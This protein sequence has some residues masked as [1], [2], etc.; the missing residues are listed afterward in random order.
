[1]VPDVLELHRE[2]HFSADVCA[3]LPH[4]ACVLLGNDD[5]GCGD[6]EEFMATSLPYM[7]STG[8]ISKILQKVIEARR[9]DRFTQDFLETK[10]GFSGGSA[11]AMIPFMKRLGFLANDGSPTEL[12][13]RF[14]NP[15]TQGE[16][17]AQAMKHGFR[18][19]YDAN[20]YAHD[21]SA[22]KLS[23]LITQITGAEKDA[24]TTNCTVRTFANLKKFADF[25]KKDIKE[26]L[27]IKFKANNEESD[28]NISPPPLRQVSE[29]DLKLSYTINLNLPES[30]NPDVFN[31]IFKALRENL[32]SER[33]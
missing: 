2:T 25:E 17:M 18:A 11:M 14:R 16:A 24:Q 23:A 33:S 29:V 31:A 4:V 20:E 21:L 6:S 9:P 7:V 32:L 30:T 12:Y 5:S 19:L 28:V 15:E 10:L 22:E 27:P 13:D 3:K 26:V 1:L 8:L